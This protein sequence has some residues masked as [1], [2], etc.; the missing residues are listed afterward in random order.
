MVDILKYQ[1]GYCEKGRYANKII[2]PTFNADGV[3][4][5]FVARSFEK[6]PYVKYR[7]PSVSRNIIPNEHLINWKWREKKPSFVTFYLLKL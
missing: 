1:I 4:D 2:I 5:Y 3:L 6:E 7:N